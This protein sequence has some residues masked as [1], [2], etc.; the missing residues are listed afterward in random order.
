M[1]R[2]TMSADGARS[3]E[4]ELE[5]RPTAPA[6]GPTAAARSAA[7]SPAS[8]TTLARA[9]QHEL[10]GDLDLA[11]GDVERIRVA[12]AARSWLPTSCMPRT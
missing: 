9:G 4:L 10:D 8:S 5:R 7:S 3:M 11:Q 6:R 1:R 2:L 12:D